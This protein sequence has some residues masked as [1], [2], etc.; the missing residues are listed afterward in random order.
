M[1]RSIAALGLSGRAP[2]PTGRAT[3][4]ACV[5]FSLRLIAAQV[6]T[7]TGEVGLMQRRPV[8]ALLEFLARSARARIVASD[9]WHGSA[10]GARIAR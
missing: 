2:V 10:K 6:A 8:T 3:P 9:L 1:T 7:F 4:P 5:T